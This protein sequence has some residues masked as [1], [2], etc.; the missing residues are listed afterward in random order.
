ML[1]ICPQLGV[2]FP[3]DS[4]SWNVSGTPSVRTAKQ[5]HREL[6]QLV[7]YNVLAEP[8]VFFQFG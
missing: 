2:G 1:H 5:M 3:A 6:S 8:S 4:S 7:S